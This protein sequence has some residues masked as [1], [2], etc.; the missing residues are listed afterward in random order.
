MEQTDNDRIAELE[1]VIEGLSH[2]LDE[3]ESNAE[4]LQ[5]GIDTLK[6]K[7]AQA[8]SDGDTKANERGRAL[9]Q[10][11]VGFLVDSGR[12]HVASVVNDEFAPK[13]KG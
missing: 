6:T 11:I 3:A 9:L 1:Q 12:P 2:K 7:L 10:G 13:V 4:G 5:M 8:K